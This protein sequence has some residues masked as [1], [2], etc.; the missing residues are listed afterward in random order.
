VL[1]FLFTTFE[2]EPWS[3]VGIHTEKKLEERRQGGIA[4][5]KG[6]KYDKAPSSMGHFTT[7]SVKKKQRQTLFGSY[8]LGVMVFF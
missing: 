7:R 5:N 4:K 6:G 2:T 8:L 3:D 1:W